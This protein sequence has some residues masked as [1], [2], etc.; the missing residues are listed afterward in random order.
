MCSHLWALTNAYI[1]YGGNTHL[2]AHKLLRCLSHALRQ[3]QQARKAQVNSFPTLTVQ[4][5]MHRLPLFS[6]AL[7]HNVSRFLLLC[8]QSFLYGFPLRLSCS[9][10]TSTKARTVCQPEAPCRPTAPEVR[11]KEII[12]VCAALKKTN[13]STGQIRQQTVIG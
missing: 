6:H 9:A 10:L 3:T 11:N 12:M 1:T 13:R 7:C 5:Y 2:Y 4:I 8:C